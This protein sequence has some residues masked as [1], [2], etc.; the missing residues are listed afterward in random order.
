MLC[1]FA[2]TFIHLGTTQKRLSLSSILFI[3]LKEKPNGWDLFL[4][5][6]KIK[7]NEK[8]TKN[9]PYEGFFFFFFFSFVTLKLW[10]IFPPKK[11]QNYSN[12]HQ[13]TTFS[14]KKIP[15]FWFKK[16]QDLSRKTT[17]PCLHPMVEKQL[18]HTISNGHREVSVLHLDS[19]YLLR[20]QSN[21]GKNRANRD[22]I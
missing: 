13:K 10:P 7:E 1:V 4:S 16:R 20:L 11:N 2:S 8:K 18:T 21:G 12:L 5:N 3:H 14:K 22:H 6:S 9:S 19:W 15:I 17:G